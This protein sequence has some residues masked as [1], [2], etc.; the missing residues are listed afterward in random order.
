MN[1]YNDALLKAQT[2]F[3]DVERTNEQ[4]AKIAQRAVLGLDYVF[5]FAAKRAKIRDTFTGEECMIL[6]FS[7]R[8]Y[9]RSEKMNITFETGI[10]LYGWEL[11]CPV[12][13]AEYIGRVKDDF[14]ERIAFLGKMGATLEDFGCD[15][16]KSVVDKTHTFLKYKGGLTYQIARDYTILELSHDFEKSFNAFLGSDI[17]VYL[18]LDASE[19]EVFEFFVN[20]IDA[21]YRANYA[22]YRLAYQRRKQLEKQRAKEAEN[23]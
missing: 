22:L 23:A 6:P 11:S 1:W 10:G 17:K 18:S 13:N 14:W 16:K 20:G 15:Y 7:V 5:K 3:D 2:Y 19:D 12:E 21:M 9:K 4:L 8:D